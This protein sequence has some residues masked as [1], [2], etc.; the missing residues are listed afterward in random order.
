MKN[1][2]NSDSIYLYRLEYLFN[3]ELDI[4]ITI[5]AI[6]SILEEQSLIIKKTKSKIEKTI[7]NDDYF[8]KLKIE[9]RSDYINQVYGFETSAIDEI[10]SHQM[11]SLCLLTYSVIEGRLKNICQFLENKYQYKIKIEDL[12]TND[13]LMR[14]WNYLTKVYE[15]NPDKV[16]K[17]F[18]PI[19]QQKVVR[20]IIAHQ[21]GKPRK[22]QV[23]KLIIVKGLEIKDYGKNYQVLI[24]GN[25]Y[26]EFLLYNANHFFKELLKSIDLRYTEIE[27]KK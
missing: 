7:K 15:I 20:N 3:I 13:D 23:S 4:E 9:D 26:I 21:D 10:Y 18:T 5:D 25:D 8:K 24:K 11:N 27:I 1:L 17:Y 16:E 2:F 14:Y 6:T 12:S 19:K 22:E